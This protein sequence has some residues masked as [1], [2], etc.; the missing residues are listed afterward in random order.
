MTPIRRRSFLK[1]SL[2]AG[3]GLAAGRGP[4]ASWAQDAPKVRG[5]IWLWM[6]GGMSPS[7]TWDPKAAGKTKAIDTTIGDIQVS[8]LMKVSASQ[9]TH[10]SILRTVTHGYVDPGLAAWAMHAAPQSGFQTDQPLLGTILAKELARELTPLPPHLVLDGPT[11]SEA[12]V[13]GER[14]LPFVI[15]SIRDPIPN[16]RRSVDAARDLE[17]GKLLLGQNQEWS[18]LRQQR[19]VAK[20]DNSLLLSEELMK[21]PALRVFNLLD[22]P[23]SLREEYGEGF[24]E[25]CLLARRL[26]ESGC[27]FVEL[28]LRGWDSKPTLSLA[29]VLDRALGTLVKD[30]AEKNLLRETLVVC[31]T[32]FGR[33]MAFPQAPAP[34]GFS[35]VLA[36]GSLAGGRVYGDTG[37]W[38]TDSKSPVSIQD[39]FATLYKACGVDAGKLYVREGR[40][41]K[42]LSG[43][44]PIDDLF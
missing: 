6:E 21:T 43:G 28:G 24:G 32:E 17:R 13:F 41:F 29:P 35:V 11:F 25:H 37:P 20:Q 36:G 19:E 22:E 39:L 27:A 10:L 8:E 9:M 33:G 12:P 1:G 42:Y 40:K 44:K 3:L 16:L 26:M 15:P 4:L 7:F 23:A 5:V 2:A 38:G 18:S 30:L 31:A 34:R 14:V